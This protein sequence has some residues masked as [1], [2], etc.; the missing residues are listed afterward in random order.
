VSQP[1]SC[2]R[3]CDNTDCTGGL[4]CCGAICQARCE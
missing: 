1:G 4:S 2:A 3:C